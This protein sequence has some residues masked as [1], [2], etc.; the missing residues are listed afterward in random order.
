MADPTMTPTE[1]L[2][3]EALCRSLREL[4]A[5]PTPEQIQKSAK[6][7]S[8]AAVQFFLD[9]LQR[10][11]LIR[12]DASRPRVIEVVCGAL[13]EASQP[14]GATPAEVE[15]PDLRLPED[16]QPT[17][18]VTVAATDEPRTISDPAPTHE[19]SDA[20]SATGTSVSEPPALLDAG[21][22]DDLPEGRVFGRGEPPAA[23]DPTMVT[24]PL[25]GQVAAGRPLDSVPGEVQAT[26]QLPRALVGQ[27]DPL[28]MLRVHGAS[29]IE[30][31]IYEEDLVVAHR[32][33]EVENGEI[34]I[35]CDQYGDAAV[36]RF[37]R[38][39]D[40]RRVEL[41]SASPN[42]GA[43]DLTEAEILGR[44]VAVIREL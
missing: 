15:E 35:V 16:R 43:L 8:L 18:A 7:P 28:F 4:G 27:R 10:K 38:S 41:R 40:G 14:S 26:Y 23:S 12:Q 24:V 32:R 34:V 39:D 9:N 44:V 25:V 21:E 29:M 33:Q 17:P 6:L 42:I 36:K 13:E 30:L 19:P 37:W 31:G 22:A 2:V 11:K 3:L 1:R 20:L 5:P